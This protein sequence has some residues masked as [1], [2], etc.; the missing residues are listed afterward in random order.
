MPSYSASGSPS[1]HLAAR[2]TAASLRSLGVCFAR[3]FLRSARQRS[4]DSAVAR[5]SD[6]RSG[7]SVPASAVAVTT[8]LARP[9][10]RFTRAHSASMESSSATASMKR[11]RPPERASAHAHTH[12]HSH[13]RDVRAPFPC[14]CT[15]ARPHG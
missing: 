12:S 8:V 9:T 2:A 13:P 5:F 11:K 7:G 4:T 14:Y 6:A 3:C 15:A 10:A 1:V